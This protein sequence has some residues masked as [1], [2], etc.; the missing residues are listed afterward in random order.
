MIALRKQSHYLREPGWPNPKS[1]CTTLTLALRL[2]RRYGQRVPTVAQLMNDFSV[3][4]ATAYRWRA[5]F[6][7]AMEAAA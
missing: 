2:V 7:E 5:A 6:V 3:C 4:R 1:Q